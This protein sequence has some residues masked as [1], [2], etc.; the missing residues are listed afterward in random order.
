M[1]RCQ[2]TKGEYKFTSGFFKTKEKKKKTDSQ[3]YHNDGFHVKFN[4]QLFRKEEKN[5]SKYKWNDVN[6]QLDRI[7]N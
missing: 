4:S 5:Y 3:Q 6:S 1:R 2:F 7:F